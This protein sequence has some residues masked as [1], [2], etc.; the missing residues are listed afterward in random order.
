M[1]SSVKSIVYNVFLLPIPWFMRLNLSKTKDFVEATN[2]P[3]EGNA[4]INCVINRSIKGSNSILADSN[5]FIT[6]Q[7]LILLLGRF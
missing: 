3:F 7:S 4:S 5:K 1:L 2:N 6:V